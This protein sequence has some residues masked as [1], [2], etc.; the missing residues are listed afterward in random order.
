MRHLLLVLL[1]ALPVLAQ[2]EEPVVLK[3]PGMDR[4]EV[5]KDIAY[6]EHKLDLYRPANAKGALPVVIFV[7]GIDRAELKEWGQYTSWPRLAAVRGMA[8]VTHTGDLN[9]LLTAIKANA[10]EWGLDAKRIAIWACSANG[11]VGTATL[12]NNDELRAAVLYYALMETPPKNVTT[13]VLVARAGLDALTLNASIERWLAQAL[14]LEV[15]VSFVNYPEGRHGFELVD[16]TPES[17]Q[18][19]EQTLDF[20]QHHLNTAPTPRKEPMR[21]SELQALGADAAVQR[22]HELRKTHPTAYVLQEQVLNSLGYSLLAGKKTAE[23]VRML[24]LAAAWYPDSANAHD[25]LGDAYEAAG[26][27]AEAIKE[28]ERALQLLD[29]AHPQRR[30]GIR[31]SAEEKLKRLRQ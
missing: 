25:S 31:A 13:P 26:R 27:T 5:R 14:T 21:L 4:V 7:N 3:L 15:P 11:R 30:E 29:K 8:A 24:E 23:A 17:R 20:L 12:A 22:L 10:G 1:F 16:D 9:A 18:I 28:S 6:G 2:T 19:V